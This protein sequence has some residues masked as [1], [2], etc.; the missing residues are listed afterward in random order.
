MLGEHTTS[1]AA[2]IFEGEGE[3]EGEGGWA[4]DM[5]CMAPADKNVICIYF[6]DISKSIY[7]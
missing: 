4:M 5:L 7:I 3:G 2:R 1:S 6:R